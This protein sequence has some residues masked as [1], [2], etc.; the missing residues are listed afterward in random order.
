LNSIILVSSVTGANFQV[1]LFLLLV[2]A[3]QD[4]KLACCS[5]QKGMSENKNRNNIQAA[6]MEELKE[7]EQELLSL[8][9]MR[10]SLHA[11]ECMVG[12]LKQNVLLAIKNGNTLADLNQG[13]DIFFTGKK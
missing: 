3:F 7:L 4:D 6:E 8:R 5:R 13:W 12:C 11:V 1:D 10:S 9:R 2:S